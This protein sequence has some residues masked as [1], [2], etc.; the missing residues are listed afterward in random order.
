MQTLKADPPQKEQYYSFLN[1]MFINHY[2]FTVSIN[3]YRGSGIVSL[4]LYQQ[5]RDRAILF[6]GL[7]LWISGA[8]NN[9]GWVKEE[10]QN[11]KNNRYIL[12]QQEQH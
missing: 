6:Q 11:V 5:G 9:Y 2:S 1:T 3:Q 12:C 10:Q 8:S 4:S 7:K